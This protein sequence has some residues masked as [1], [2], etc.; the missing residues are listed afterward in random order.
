MHILLFFD[1]DGLVLYFKAYLSDIEYKNDSEDKSV[2]VEKIVDGVLLFC[3]LNGT[4]FVKLNKAIVSAWLAGVSDYRMLF[5][6]FILCCYKNLQIKWVKKSRFP[7]FFQKS[8]Y[9][10]TVASAFVMLMAS[11][12]DSFGQADVNCSKFQKLSFSPEISVPI[13]QLGIQM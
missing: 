3:K 1:D 7:C 13:F 8:I 2:T 9:S 6:H 10:D 5:L 11:T 12:G 4:S